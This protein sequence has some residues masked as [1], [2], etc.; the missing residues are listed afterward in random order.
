MENEINWRHKKPTTTTT[1]IQDI[2]FFFFCRE[3]RKTKGM[4]HDD[5]E[6]LIRIIVGNVRR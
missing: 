1:N 2:C 5:G 4:S 3:K 6:E